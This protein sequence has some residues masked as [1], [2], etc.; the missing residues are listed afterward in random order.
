VPTNSYRLHYGQSQ[1]PVTEIVPDPSGLYRIAWP[2]VGLS[3]LAV[4]SD[5]DPSRHGRCQYQGDNNDVSHP[6]CPILTVLHRKV[7][8]K[9]YGPEKPNDAAYD[10]AEI[11]HY[12][13]SKWPP[14]RQRHAW[15]C[16]AQGPGAWDALRPGP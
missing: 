5:R 4:P 12:R 13:E 2:D 1:T 7:E 10:E 9:W 15:S 3:D 11:V 16:R 6:G 8:Q 14:M